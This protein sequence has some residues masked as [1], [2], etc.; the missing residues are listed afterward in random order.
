MNHATHSFII[1]TIAGLTT[2]IGALIIFIKSDKRNNIICSSLSFSAGVMIAISIFDLIPTSFKYLSDTYNIIPAMLVVSL[3]TIIGII[4]SFFISKLIPE[5]KED[6]NNLFRTGILSM[7]VL[8]LHNIPEGI[9][10]FITSM[11]DITFGITIALAISLHNIP[12][13]ISI[14]VPI[15]YSTN[16]KLKPFIYTFIAGISEL[17]G[18]MLT[19]KFLYPYMNDLIL[20]FLFA[21][22]GGLMIHIAISELLPSANRYGSINKI[23]KEVIY[24]A[25]LMLICHYLLH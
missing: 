14:A 25:I 24:A 4:I 21:I 3:F 16:S 12:E 7:I 11:N 10:T 17:F 15:Y 2:L 1:S 9:A 8:M 18:A 13:G 6:N 20:S 19:Y 23:I 22:I 5:K